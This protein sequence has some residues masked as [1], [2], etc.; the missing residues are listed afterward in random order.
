M[1]INQLTK[2]TFSS[3]PK[4]LIF[5]KSSSDNVSIR[6][7]NKPRLSESKNSTLSN[8]DTGKIPSVESQRNTTDRLVAVTESSATN[9]D[10]TDESSVCS[11]PLPP[12]KKLDGAEPISGPKTIKSILMSK[13]TF[14]T[15]TLKGIIINEPSSEPAR[16]N[17]SS[18]ASKTNSASTGKLKNIKMED[19]PP[20]AFVMK[21]LNELKLQISKNKKITLGA[22]QLLEGKRVC[23]SANKQQSVAMFSAKAKDVA[24][25]GCCA[26]ILWIKS[27]L[28]EYDIIY[29]KIKN[30]TLKRDT[31]FHFIPTQY[32]LA[33]IFNKLMDKPSIKRLIDELG[34]LNIDS[35]P[36]AFVLT[37]E[38]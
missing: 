34:M 1:G 37:E 21:E 2:D 35:K 15:E 38:N 6:D 9:Y 3:R 27:Q 26:N 14:K 32:Q 13:S 11:T 25:A 5:V 33:D 22:C 16:G 31:E 28:T 10:S 23:C 4:D 7:S 17:K 8:H 30:H 18:S 12:L 24:V 20:L 36:E 19:D 29:E